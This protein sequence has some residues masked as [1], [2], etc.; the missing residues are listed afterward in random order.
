MSARRALRLV[1]YVSPFG[2]P[3]WMSR[4]EA[5]THLEED[6]RL[7]LDLVEIG[8][9]TDAQRRVGPPRIEHDRGVGR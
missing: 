4:E 3:A 2:S 5:A 7:Y 8:A 1:R 6:D 9:L